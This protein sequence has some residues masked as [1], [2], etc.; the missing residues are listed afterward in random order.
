[1]RYEHFKIFFFAVLKLRW[2]ITYEIYDVHM[3][4]KRKKIK[5]ME[6]RRVK[7]KFNRL[8]FVDSCIGD[9]WLKPC[10]GIKLQ[11]RTEETNRWTI[12][13]TPDLLNLLFYDKT[14]CTMFCS[15]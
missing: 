1:M 9:C 6:R 12:L 14:I 5:M 3:I 8:P 11:I 7:R 15:F 13:S 2:I 10:T 4:R